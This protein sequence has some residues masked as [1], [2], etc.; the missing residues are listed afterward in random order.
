MPIAFDNEYDNKGRIARTSIQ[1]Y[2]DLI[3]CPEC[4]NRRQVRFDTRK[5]ENAKIIEIKNLN[6]SKLVV[7]NTTLNLE[8]I[9]AFVVGRHTLSVGLGEEVEV[10][11]DLY[12]VSQVW[13]SSRFGTRVNSSGGIGEP[14]LYIRKMKY[15]KRQREI[16]ITE[17]DEVN[18]ERFLSY[19]DYLKRVISLVAPHIHG[20]E[21]EKLAGLLMI[22]GAAPKQRQ[23]WYSRE[24]INTTFVGDIGAAKTEL[25]RSIIALVPGSQEINAK[26]STGKGII[27]IAER[28]GDG[29][30]TLRTGA[31][32]LANGRIC[33]V[34]EVGTFLFEEQEQLLQVM[35]KGYFDFRKMGINQRVYAK[36]PLLLT[37]NPMGKGGKWAS[38]DGI[39][40]DEIPL[41]GQ[42][43][44]RSDLIH[45]FRLPRTPQEIREHNDNKLALASKHFRRN[46]DGLFDSI[47][48]RKLLYWLKNHNPELE[49]VVFEN[50]EL[51]DRLNQFRTEM[52]I[53]LADNGFLSGR[54]WDS[55]FRV[56]SAL[57]RLMCKKK[58]DN[59]VV[60]IT[61]QFLRR[62]YEDFGMQIKD[63]IES[64]D[65]AYSE[66]IKVV[67]DRYESQNWMAGIS[68][69]Q[70]DEI[71]TIPFNEAAQTARDR[72]D[73]VAYYLGKN[74]RD[75]NNRPMRNLKELFREERKCDG[76]RVRAISK[77]KYSELKL[78]WEPDSNSNSNP[79]GE[80]VN[81]DND[82]GV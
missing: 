38:P 41:K 35:D 47:H 65:L 39:S 73:Q 29:G 81:N 19:P 61:I 74:F 71:T 6:T 52:D 12:I 11:A 22:L 79:G 34:D 82:N 48:L 5:Y 10:I 14:I 36:T 68:E 24:W 25:M 49:N 27:A 33:G 17:R 66:I 9:R 8:H 20:H 59:E 62:R 72:N 69:E 63:F 28:Q 4:R 54:N 3:I 77:S 64:K 46:K 60:E 7:A 53:K 42:L 23:N 43:I 75:P 76:G 31:I 55:L 18:F 32:A 78:R 67:K 30:A 15:T 13:T 26:H 45:I 44:D 37:A 1:K 57:A 40:L 56:A 80:G 50:T 58:I 51:E 70:I 21:D 16:N 2:N